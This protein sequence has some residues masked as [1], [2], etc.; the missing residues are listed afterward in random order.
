MPDI[1]QTISSPPVASGNKT[2]KIL[3]V[4]SVL[5]LLA[6]LI[7][8]LKQFM[9]KQSVTKRDTQR[10]KDLTSLKVALEKARAKSKDNLYYPSAITAVSLE[11]PGFIGKIPKDPTSNPPYVYN[12]LGGPDTCAGDCTTFK[13]YACLENKNDPE[14]IAPIPPCETKSY[15]VSND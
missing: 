7:F 4:L 1:P 11:K 5:I 8:A 6:V 2:K 13:L 15:Q 10:K 3:I 14:G 12:Y 9:D